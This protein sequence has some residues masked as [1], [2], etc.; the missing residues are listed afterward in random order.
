MSRL[1]EQLKKYGKSGF[2]SMH[3]P[4]HK[5]KLCAFDITEISDFDNLAN[6]GGILKELEESWARV[7]GAKTAHI[8]VNGSTGAILSAIC[9]SINKGDKIIMARNCHKSVYNAAELMEAKQSYIFP[10][11]DEI[12]I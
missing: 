8:S 7:Y 3:M 2:Y 5:G 11:Y 6:P 4:G 10:D 1:Y 12:G 9:G